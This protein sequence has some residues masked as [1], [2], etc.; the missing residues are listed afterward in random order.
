MRDLLKSLVALGEGE[1]KDT[2]TGRV[3]KGNYGSEYETDREGN[4]T[5]KAAPEVKKGRGRPKKDA[6]ASGEVKKY[7]TSS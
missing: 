3:H 7:D 4:E 5:K 2:K 6:D 1:T